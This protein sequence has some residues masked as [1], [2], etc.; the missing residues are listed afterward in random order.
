LFCHLE[1]TSTTTVNAGSSFILN[2]RVPAT[3]NNIDTTPFS[4][5]A[6]GYGWN[7]SGSYDG[8]FRA[9]YKGFYRITISCRFAD[10]TGS[11][12][13]GLMPKKYD[14]ST[15]TN[16]LPNDGVLWAW[17]DNPSSNR[18]CISYTFTVLLTVGLAVYVTPYSN[19]STTWAHFD[20]EF[21]TGVL[22]NPP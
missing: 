16:I 13:I 11:T 19:I 12:T 18:N 21:V 8:Y 9:P 6:L 1:M 10:G 2:S 20:I 14:G 15:F 5:L 17:R 7:Y 4:L 3:S 22:P